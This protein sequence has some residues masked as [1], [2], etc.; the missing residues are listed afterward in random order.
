M[1]RAHF[2]SGLVPENKRRSSLSITDAL[3]S[4]KVKRCSYGGNGTGTKDSGTGT[5]RLL[6]YQ[7]TFGTGTTL[8]GTGTNMR[9]L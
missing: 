4:F 1:S 2:R 5:P 7:C 3:G 6:E 8:T 9:S